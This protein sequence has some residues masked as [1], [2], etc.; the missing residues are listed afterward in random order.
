MMNECDVYISS[1][2]YV[3]QILKRTGQRLVDVV[4]KNELKKE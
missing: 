3:Y 4:N 2:A 1:G